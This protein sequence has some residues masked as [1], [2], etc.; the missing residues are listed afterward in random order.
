MIMSKSDEYLIHQNTKAAALKAV[1]AQG[2]A[3]AAE[4]TLS[5]P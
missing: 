5:E 1:A 2:R 3:T 4:R